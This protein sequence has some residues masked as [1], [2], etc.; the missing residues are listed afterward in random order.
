MPHWIFKK[1]RDEKQ[2]FFL[3]M[4]QMLKESVKTNQIL[5]RL[6]AINQREARLYNLF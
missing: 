4:A 5:A 6:E 1:K 3:A 2:V